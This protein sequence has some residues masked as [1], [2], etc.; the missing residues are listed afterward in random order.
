MKIVRR[1]PK[2]FHPV[3][4][5]LG[6]ALFFAGLYFAIGLQSTVNYMGSSILFLLSLDAMTINFEHWEFITGI[7]MA[8]TGIVFLFISS[9]ESRPRADGR[10]RFIVYRAVLWIGILLAL[11]GSYILFDPSTGTD[12]VNGKIVQMMYLQLGAILDFGI[13]FWIGSALIL[14]GAII[15]SRFSFG[16]E[17]AV[18]AQ[19]PEIDAPYAQEQT[20][21]AVPAKQTEAATVPIAR[22]VSPPPPA[23]EWVPIRAAAIEA[24]RIPQAPVS[25]GRYPAP[26][27]T[28]RPIPIHQKPQ[29]ESSAKENEE[30]MIEIE[31]QIVRQK[32]MEKRARIA[33]KSAK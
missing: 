24:K 27:Q 26:I 3:R 16:R 9:S 21:I 20:T 25:A 33:E 10:K 11:F 7:I 4:F 22:V 28:A 5:L 23:Q 19:P 30:R 32:L 29:P 1:N 14:L 12:M 13:R 17:K 18:E 2:I 15:I 6:I 31:R 8:V